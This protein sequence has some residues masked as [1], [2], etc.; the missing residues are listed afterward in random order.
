MD[1]PLR[2]GPASPK[3]SNH[4]VDVMRPARTLPY[5]AESPGYFGFFALKIF[6]FGIFLEGKV[7]YSVGK[8]DVFSHVV[9]GRFMNVFAVA[10]L[11]SFVASLFLGVLVLSLDP[12]RRLNQVF[13]LLCCALAGGALVEFGYRSSV[14]FNQAVFWW[15]LDFCWPL[16]P[17]FL[18][19]FVLLF[20]RRERPAPRLL[21]ALVYGVSV[22]LLGLEVAGVWITAP[23]EK[24][25]WGWTYGLPPQR[26][27]AWGVTL[28]GSGV[29]F[30]GVVL[31]MRYFF[32]TQSR[33]RKRQAAL[34][35]LGALFPYLACLIVDIVLQSVYGRFPDV[36]YTMFV[37]SG[38]LVAFAIWKY[39]TFEL[40]P[41]RAVD[42]ILATMPDAMFLADANGEITVANPAASLLLGYALTEL[43]GLPLNHVL[44]EIA[45]IPGATPKA[46]R[47]N[48]SA[49]SLKQHDTH[50]LT[51]EG[52][53]IPADLSWTHLTDPAGRPLGTVFV[54]HD[55]S[56][57]K[58][59]E[60]E[61]ARQRDHLERIVAQRTSELDASTA[62]LHQAQ[63]MEAVGQLAGGIAH[64]FNNLLTAILGNLS[65]AQTEET[66]RG[67]RPYIE[68]ANKAG[69]RAAGLVQQLLAFSRKSQVIIE[70][71]DMGAIL[72]E[73]ESIV[74]QTFDRRIE[75][76]FVVPPELPKVRTDASQI[77]QV[78]LNLCVNAR[79]AL[80]EVRRRHKT[81]NLRI[82]VQAKTVAVS[83]SDCRGK[84][85]SK[86][87]EYICVSVS[88]TG[89]GISPHVRARMFEPFFTTKGAGKGTG[90][91]L[92]TAYSIVE[93]HGGWIDIETEM[94]AG[95]TF[96]AYFP[97]HAKPTAAR[98]P[99][100]GRLR[101]LGGSESILL[102]DDELS[103]RL[104]GK[105]ILERLGYA[106]TL[107]V[108][109]RQCLHTLFDKE[110]AIDLVILDLSMPELSGYEVLAEIRRRGAAVPVIISSGYPQ[111]AS[112]LEAAG[113]AAS[114]NKPF[115]IEAMARSIRHVLDGQA[116]QEHAVSNT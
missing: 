19:H 13:F 36:G 32:R 58:R 92:A 14:T 69:L 67:A 50:L 60:A 80:D 113:A 100:D 112:E 85:H 15:H 42:T 98:A 75:L 81:P 55:I 29:G 111:D 87:G 114:V 105:A 21:L 5:F 6:G 3:R 23:S 28:W 63:K 84:K 106:V 26:A 49:P 74:R 30:T 68:E 62:Q 86:P 12:W 99:Q 97:V 22:A 27:W 107:A 78:I 47:E 20:T 65:L 16:I 31:C 43:V 51:R 57:R 93:R 64:D 77:H 34:I 46:S 24:T 102:V 109:G 48:H 82:T 44:P 104:V 17:A 115:T 33:W 88:D 18:L 94:G 73:I 76:A 90:L 25:W 66:I 7:E 35:T 95:S 8:G 108:D 41:R 40:T 56:R 11:L 91:G 2:R 116:E 96:L 4:A 53:S 52:R 39:H 103:I 45:A 54:A 10:S 61:L 70:A 9:G 89:T 110:A 72:K 59:A 37:I 79:D 83:A 71:V 101:L 38:A 1:F